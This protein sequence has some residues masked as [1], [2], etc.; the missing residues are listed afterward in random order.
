[1]ARR[2]VL[3]LLSLVCTP[4]VV[5][6]AP[7][8]RTPHPA[9]PHTA[10][11]A[12]NGQSLSG[13]EALEAARKSWHEAEYE[14]AETLYARAIEAGGLPIALATEAYLYRGAALAILG[15]TKPAS[16]S[17]RI[18]LTVD[19]SAR[20][21][22]EAGKKAASLL[23]SIRKEKLPVLSLTLTAPGEVHAGEAFNADVALGE[24]PWPIIESVAVTAQETTASKKHSV[25]IRPAQLSTVELPNW[26]AAAEGR[27]IAL[28][29]ELRDKGGNVLL[30][31]EK[32]VRVKA[33]VA[34]VLL[35]TEPKKPPPKEPPKRG[36][37]SS[38]WPYVLGGV[39]LVGAAGSAAYG[40]GAFQPTEANVAGAR[41][42]PGR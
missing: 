3:C 2:S 26:L 38:P 13:R 12:P 31:A 22:P 5:H 28:H 14:T 17:L 40:L 19:G 1:M 34:A 41:V 21:P 24:N 39:V 18:A 33:T 8:V 27:T 16:E 10:K 35:A 32:T 6:A 29:A 4:P 20:M 36:F 23:E 11:D 42:V 15:K 7:A 37:W 9:P 25:T 30:T